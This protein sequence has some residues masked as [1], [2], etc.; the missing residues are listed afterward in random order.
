MIVT[1]SITQIRLN[2]PYVR[3]INVTDK[4]IADKV[5]YHLTMIN[6]MEEMDSGLSVCG[7]SVQKLL[8][9]I[10]EIAD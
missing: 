1:A 6:N 3:L 2:V 8:R 7:K 5:R 9:E 4:E 10:L